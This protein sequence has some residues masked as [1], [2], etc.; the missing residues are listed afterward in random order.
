MSQI[1][2]S[3]GSSS[4]SKIAAMFLSTGADVSSLILGPALVFLAI[5]IIGYLVWLSFAVV[6]PMQMETFSM[7]W[8]GTFFIGM[9]ILCNLAF[10]YFM[11]VITDPG[12]PPA[13]LRA[14]IQLKLQ[15]EVFNHMDVAVGGALF[16]SLSPVGPRRVGHSSGKSTLSTKS[17]VQQELRKRAPDR[18]TEQL[19]TA[20]STDIS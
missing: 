19:E 15:R 1:H 20:M 16:G 2:Q 8:W 7:A 14:Q 12:S 6:A 4:A 17:T 10:H 13:S 18:E 3:F 5:G 9:W 11:C